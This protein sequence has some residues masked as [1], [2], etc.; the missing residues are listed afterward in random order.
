MYI[1]I[2]LCNLKCIQLLSI[3]LNKAEK[4]KSIGEELRRGKY[5]GQAQTTG[6]F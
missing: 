3:I 1:K 4:K 5:L 6:E 2:S